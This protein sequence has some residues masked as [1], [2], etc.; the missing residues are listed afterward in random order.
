MQLSVDGTGHATARLADTNG[1]FV[2][3]DLLVGTGPFYVV[4]AQREGLP[5]TVG[6]NIAIWHSISVVTGTNPP[7]HR[8]VILEK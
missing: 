1:N 5:V 4:L 7:V 8:V 3:T 2:R 6:T